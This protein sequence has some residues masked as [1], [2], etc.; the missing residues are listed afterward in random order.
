LQEEQT[1]NLFETLPVSPLQQKSHNDMFPSQ[2]RPTKT[3]SNPA[4]LPKSFRFM[5]GLSEVNIFLFLQ[6]KSH[7]TLLEKSETE[8]PFASSWVKHSAPSL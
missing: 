1:I 8:Q 5:E 3:F 6:P 2:G 7:S 4:S